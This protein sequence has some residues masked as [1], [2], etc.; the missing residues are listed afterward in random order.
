MIYYILW[1]YI[2]PHYG[3]Y[4]IRQELVVVDADSGANTHR[5]LKIPN[6]ELEAWDRNHDARGN[7]ASG[8]DIED[9][10]GA[11]RRVADLKS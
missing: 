1:I 2:L 10:F 11:S 7:L 8:S 6:G 5:L 9:V 4:Q 3:G